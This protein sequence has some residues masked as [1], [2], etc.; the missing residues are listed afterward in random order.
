M[1][2][3]DCDS[4]DRVAVC[5]KKFTATIF[6]QCVVP[7]DE[8]HSV[9]IQVLE[10][11]SSSGM[12]G[13]LMMIGI[14]NDDTSGHATHHLGAPGLRNS[15]GI[16]NRGDLINNGETIGSGL[17][18][19]AGDVVSMVFNNGSLSIK[20]NGTEAVSEIAN[21]SFKNKFRWA[22]SF[23]AKGQAV[24]LGA[25]D[26][27]PSEDKFCTQHGIVV[28]NVMTSVT[29]TVCSDSPSP[30]EETLPGTKQGGCKS[31][32]LFEQGEEVF[33]C[34]NGPVS[35]A[36]ILR[37]HFD[38]TSEPYYT[39]SVDGK[40]KQ[41][42]Q[43]HLFKSYHEAELGPK[44]T[45]MTIHDQPSLQS[46]NTSASSQSTSIAGCFI[47]PSDLK[48]GGKSL[49]EGSFGKVFK[50]KWDDSDVAVKEVPWE[51]SDEQLREIAVGCSLAQPN[52]AT[53]M[54]WSKKGG[55]KLLIVMPL[56]RNGSLADRLSQINPE[57]TPSPATG[58]PFGFPFVFRI[59]LGLLRAIK[60]M[61]SRQPHAVV[62]RDI[63]P[64]NILLD[65]N[66]RP[67]LTDFGTARSLTRTMAT[68][69]RVGT[70]YYMAAEQAKE[71]ETSSATDVYAA[72]LVI[73]ETLCAPRTVHDVTKTSMLKL[74]ND[75]AMGK[76]PPFE[77]IP[78]E[79]ASILK[80]AFSSNPERRPTAA[81]MVSRFEALR[82]SYSTL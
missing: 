53:I 66:D 64:A 48:Y 44:P 38:S 67:M 16:T 3:I 47:D 19:S 27:T 80:P 60:Y 42:E 49:G 77:D 26:L 59:S 68:P 31:T 45:S 39:I 63:K 6:S 14:M 57:L 69:A 4:T 70:P 36:T 56:F 24:K 10:N 41:T 82:D 28:S 55:D 21:L 23:T 81:Q 22:V 11:P 29:T 8:N 54:G 13:P 61:A 2:S 71:E 12:A 79:I 30:D 37:V 18:F 15:L 76:L 5:V 7:A 43:D 73:Y 58:G 40:E 33:Y 9:E 34:K 32:K 20:V 51:D 25:E 78:K 1:K 72:A 74:M 17:G 46:T 75:I 65:E 62:H 35:K 50:G 52:I